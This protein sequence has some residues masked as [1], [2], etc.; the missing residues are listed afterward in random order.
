MRKNFVSTVLRTSAFAMACLALAGSNV[1]AA[2]SISATA[3][4]Q[5]AP[6][7]APD[8]TQTY[9]TSLNSALSFTAGT[10]TSPDGSIPTNAIS[11]V[12]LSSGSYLGTSAIGLG[13][14]QVA[15]LP[16]GQEIDYKNTPFSFTYNPVSFSNGTATL[17]YPNSTSTSTSNNLTGP[18]TISGVLNGAIT[19]STS[20][21]VA[22]FSPITGAAFTSPDG[23]TISTLS[24]A[25]SP[26]NLVPSSAGGNTTVQANVVATAPSG[27]GTGGGNPTPTPEPTTLAILATAL[28]GL[29]LRKQLRKAR[30]AD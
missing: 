11:F 3:A 9:S 6:P 21:V 20:S 28:V 16:T 15:T 2:T 18:V 27:L 22:T 19:G 12:P 7:V 10:I 4:P 23:S 8:G 30:L 29:G 25:N 26:L 14:F 1:Q 5:V 24:I 13:V 17:P